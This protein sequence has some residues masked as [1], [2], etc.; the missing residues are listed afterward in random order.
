MQINI[1]HLYPDLLNLYGDKGNICTLLKRLEWRGIDAS[2]TT[3][4]GE[5]SLE[6]CD[7]LYLGGGGEREEAEVFEKLS[8]LKED[9][10][11]YA[12][13]GGVIVATCG[14]FELLGRLGILDIEISLAE[15]R[16][17]GNVIL[18]CEID[19]TTFS[20]AGFENHLERVDIKNHTP[21]GKVISGHGNDDKCEY[22]G[23]IYKNVFATHLHGPLLPKNPTLCDIILSKAAEKKGGNSV[24][25]EPLNDN[26]EQIA[27][28]EIKKKLLEK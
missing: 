22:E 23:V 11:A 3:V 12:E 24:A 15:K 19:S 5:L 26:F 28:S 20:V 25:L 6:N 13:D 7:I 8:P 17:I 18:E 16:L 10:K 27:L 9:L 2:V 14:G 4:D 1:L 21:L